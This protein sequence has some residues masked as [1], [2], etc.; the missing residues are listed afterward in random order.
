[1]TSWAVPSLH[2]GFR[3]S[4]IECLPIRSEA[5]TWSP[6]TTETDEYRMATPQPGYGQ[7]GQ[8]Q[9]PQQ[10]YTDGPQGYEGHTSP[11]PEGQQGPAPTGRKKRAYA[12]QAYDFGGGANSALGGQQQGG[13]VYPAPG[14]GYGA[15]PQQTQQ[16]A[17]QHPPYGVDAPA[18]A[19]GYGQPPPG[20]GGYQPPAQGYPPQPP[21]P[22]SPVGGITQQMGNLGVRGEPSLHTAPTPQ[23]PQLNQ[24]YPTDLLNQPLNVTE[25]DLPPPP[26]ILP[27]NVSYAPTLDC[28]YTDAT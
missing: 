5:I 4:D 26:I 17:Y 14:G 13:G 7:F 11:G 15:Y 9:H 12:G 27:P 3:A 16:E 2:L 10:H 18:Q 8:D 24:L 20:V 23:R 22:I 28:A 25:L 21:Q 19:P 6:S 1:M